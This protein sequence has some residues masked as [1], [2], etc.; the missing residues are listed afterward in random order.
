M[1]DDVYSVDEG[2]CVQEWATH[3]DGSSRQNP[4]VSP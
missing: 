3:V 2:F 1:L 4:E